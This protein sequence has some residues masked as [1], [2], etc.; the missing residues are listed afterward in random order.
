MSHSNLINQVSVPFNQ[1]NEPE[2]GE[3][4]QS[5]W[6]VEK[7][8]RLSLAGKFGAVSLI[9]FIIFTSVMTVGYLNIKKG[10]IAEQNRQINSYT[11]IYKRLP[12]GKFERLKTTKETADL[13]AQEILEKAIAAQGKT[14]ISKQGEAIQAILLDKDKVIVQV[15]K[16]TESTEKMGRL[17][18]TLS[19]SLAVIILCLSYW[20]GRLLSARIARLNHLTSM[21]IKGEYGRKLPVYS[22]DELGSLIGDLNQIGEQLKRKEQILSIAEKVYGIISGRNGINVNDVAD[23]KAAFGSILGEISKLIGTNK[24]SIYRFSYSSEI[25]DVYQLNNLGIVTVSQKR[26]NPPLPPLIRGE[27][28]PSLYLPHWKH[29]QVITPANYSEL[30]DQE[31]ECLKALSISVKNSSI[32]PL[33]F[34]GK[35][36]GLLVVELAELSNSQLDICAA[37]GNYILIAFVNDYHEAQLRQK[38]DYNRRLSDVIA[39]MQ[40]V[41]ESG[42]LWDVLSNSIRLNL[43]VERVL[44]YQFTES[45]QLKPVCE[46]VDAAFS[47]VLKAESPPAPLSERGLG[48]RKEE[49]TDSCFGE[50]YAQLYSEGRVRVCDS[51]ES[52]DLSDCFRDRLTELGVKAFV[53]VPIFV[54]QKLFGLLIVHRLKSAHAWQSVEVDWLSQLANVTGVVLAYGQRLQLIEKEQLTLKNSLNE[55][56]TAI[57]DL[58]AQSV[59][60]Q[61]GDLTKSLS[62]HTQE[63][64]SLVRGFNSTLDNLRSLVGVVS[65]TAM[66]LSNICQ[67]N[68]MFIESSITGMTDISGQLANLTQQGERFNETT[69]RVLASVN[70]ADVKINQSLDTV[71]SS[72]EIL[73]TTIDTIQNVQATVEQTVEKIEALGRSSQEIEKAVG[74]IGRFAAQTH[75]LALKASIEAARAGEEGRGFAVIAD[76]VRSLATSSAEATAQIEALVA[77]IEQGIADVE[78]VMKTGTTQVFSLIDLSN[79]LNSEMETLAMSSKIVQDLLRTLSSHCSAQGALGSAFKEQLESLSSYS[80]ITANSVSA[81]S[82]MLDALAVSAKGL[83]STVNRF[84]YQIRN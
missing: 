25:P 19:L 62:S 65:T 61:Q 7:F 64:D 32:V 66:D 51:V 53:V 22:G 45:W 83:S 18:F 9:I 67:G 77:S 33:V 41:S 74:L 47:S 76:E 49:I 39:A 46:S 58:A 52:D 54:S 78:T 80:R 16:K 72:K 84:S 40:R 4:T 6:W 59:K 56:K 5:F 21:L 82:E 44:V 43:K 30:T 29:N 34:A 75:L 10:I 68:Q 2:S 69:D 20:M 27:E 35:L 37:L 57:A 26:K 60:F 48:G 24:I 3:I 1:D 23:T 17:M 50:K 73:A 12:N 8:A 11:S 36:L 42:Q 38:L 71:D 28:L 15:E 79:Q 81:L 31:M 14:V 13:A 63:L 70:Q 55:L